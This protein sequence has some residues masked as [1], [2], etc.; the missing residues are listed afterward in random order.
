MVALFKETIGH[1]DIVSWLFKGMEEESESLN[2]AQ[3]SK[4]MFDA[5]KSG[6]IMI[7]EF[8]FKYYP[9]LLFEVDSREQRNLLHIAILY[10]QETVYRLILNQGIPRM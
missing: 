1:Q 3:L 2:N 9:Y 4:A 8:L 6:N 10:R 5:A 7:L